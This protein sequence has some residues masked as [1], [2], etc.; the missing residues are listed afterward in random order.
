MTKSEVLDFL[1]RNQVCFLA[2]IEG[3]KPHVR[4]MR[5]YR[6]DEEGIVFHTGKTKDLHKQL[7]ENGEAELCCAG[8][9]I[10]VRVSGRMELVEDLRL[11]K[12]IVAAR[13]F[14]KHMVDEEGYELLVV[15]RLKNGAATTWTMET[16]LAPKTYVDL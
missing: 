9:G 2:T 1:N 8:D 16:N 5:L 11:K 10:Q 15:Y 6:A 4:G 12:E 3:Q 13:P 7:Q 14:L